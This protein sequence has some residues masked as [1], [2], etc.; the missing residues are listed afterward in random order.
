MWKFGLSGKLVL[1]SVELLEKPH[2]STSSSHI[3]TFRVFFAVSLVLLMSII[4]ANVTNLY[5]YFSYLVSLDAFYIWNLISYDLCPTFCA[6]HL[7]S[8]YN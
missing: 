6:M 4:V 8:F 5:L 7:F 1:R 3:G 2:V